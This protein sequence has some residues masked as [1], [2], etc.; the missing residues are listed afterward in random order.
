[1]DYNEFSENINNHIDTLK[2]SGNDNHFI[3]LEVFKKAKELKPSVSNEVYDT[4][5]NQNAVFFAKE[6]TNQ[7]HHFLKMDED[8]LNNRPQTNDFNSR[9]DAIKSVFS[10]LNTL[11]LTE[12]NKVEVA[13]Y[14]SI[15]DSEHAKKSG[16][17]YIATMVYGSYSHPQ[18]LIC[19][20][21]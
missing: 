18:V 16:G 5:I 3:A 10:H 7:A 14:E 6:L 9:Y 4:Y 2:L 19:T 1:M 11:P 17:C 12:E 13:K 21:R 15:L 8:W 20:I